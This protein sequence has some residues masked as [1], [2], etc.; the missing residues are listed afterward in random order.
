MLLS[1][2][3]NPPAS[4]AP[5][6]D[7]A[8]RGPWLQWR[9]RPSLFEWNVAHLPIPS[10]N[11]SLEGLRIIQISDLH[12]RQRWHRIYDQLMDRLGREPPDLLLVTGD[13]VDNKR[14]HRP[15]LPVLYR[16]LDAFRARLG[17]YAI[18]GNHDRYG[19]ARRLRGTH[20]K[21]LEEPHCPV[22]VHHCGATI[23][24]IGLPGVHRRDLTQE[25]L[26]S[27]PKRDASPPPADLRIVL[28]HFPDHLRRTQE[29]L[30]P[31]LFLAGHTHGGQ[32]CLPGRIPILRHDSLPRRLC[33]GVHRVGDT[34]LVVCRGIG[35]TTIPLR[36][37]CPPEVVE[38]RLKR[39]T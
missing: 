23:E 19:M 36:V 12:L 10:L 14:D 25:V 27:L 16:M 4:T 21:V 32:C 9:L 26:H 7:R 39:E 38:L 6:L 11:P 5:R 34:W 1:G 2:P 13:F 33:S 15:A 24:L 37:F 8:A 17:C 20:V 31:D 29:I 22:L 3:D 28:S 35:T 18:L 30:R